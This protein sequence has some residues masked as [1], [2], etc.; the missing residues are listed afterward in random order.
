MITAFIIGVP[1]LRVKGL[2]LAVTTLAFAIAAIVVDLR[3]GR[4]HPGGDQLAQGGAAG[5]GAVRLHRFP[6][7]VLLPGSGALGLGGVGWWPI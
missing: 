7:V 6:Q 1:A 5:V 2:M 3:A 4:V